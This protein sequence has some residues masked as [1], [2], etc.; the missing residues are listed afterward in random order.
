MLELLDLDSATSNLVPVTSTEFFSGKTKVFHSDGLFSESIFG[1]VDSPDRSN[2]YSFIELYTNVLHPALHPIIRRLD[3]RI[4]EAMSGEKKYTIEQNG[5]LKAD[6]SGELDGMTSVVKNFDKITFRGGNKTRDDL[7]KLIDHYKKAKQIFI[8]KTLVIPPPY[9]EIVIHD[10]GEVTIQP[11]NDYYLNI[12]KLST[13]M[14]SM[15]SGT[16]FD[17]LSYRMQI[18]VNDM[19]EFLMAKMSKKSGLLR[20]HML[21]KR[22]DFSARAVIV[23][24][25]AELKPNEIGVPFKLLVKLFEPFILFELLNSGR[26]PKELLAREMDAFNGSKLSSLSLRKLFI[27]IYK[28]DDIPDALYNL[29][30]EAVERAIKGKIVIAKR[31]P[32]LH[33][34]SVQAFYPKL[35]EGNAIKLAPLKTGAFNADFDGDQM[36]L[37]V[38]VTRQ[39]ME[40]AKDKMMV[41]ISKDGNGRLSDEFDK[42]VVIGTYTLTQKPTTPSRIVTIKSPDDAFDRHIYDKVRLGGITTTAGRVIFNQTL[43]NK[44]PFVNEPVGK[45]KL[46]E[47]ANDIFNMLGQDAYW[48]FADKVVKVAFKYGTLASPTFG[49][50]DLVLPPSIT[51]VKKKVETATPQEATDLLNAA[52]KKMEKYLV[53]NQTN[54]GVMGEAGALK[55]G[56]KQTRQILVSKGLIQDTEGNVMPPIA[57]S[58]AEGF[59]NKDFFMSGAGTRKGIS[60]RVLNTADTGY[61][62]RQLVYALQRVEADPR[63]YDCKTKKF[64]RLNVTKDIAKR[65]TGR[66][67]IVN[68]KPMPISNPDQYI[69]K[70]IPLKSPL[71]CRS[72]SICSTCYGNL[73]ERNRTPFVGILAAQVFGERSTQLIMQTFH[74]GGAVNVNTVDIL[75]AT[76][77]TFSKKEM[78]SFQKQFMQKGN[79]LIAK[80][81][82]KLI[83]HKSQYID[84]RKDIVVNKTLI[85]LA[86]GYFTLISQDGHTYDVTIDSPTIINLK[87]KQ[88]KDSPEKTEILFSANEPVCTCPPQTDNFADQVKQVKHLLSGKKPW[89]SGDHYCMK[90]YSEFTKNSI[91]ADMVHFEILASH[92]LRDRGNPS[93]PARMNDHY[94]AIVVNLKNIPAL[95]SWLS[96]LS[97]EDPNKSITAGLMYDRDTQESILEKVVN[98][99]L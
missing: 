14:S 61:L 64:F 35:I 65:L 83:I 58:Y 86:Y 55:G 48:E 56:Y 4:L 87:G 71:Y 77:V 73:L 13:Q 81:N 60:D 69:G 79:D 90:L 18:Y 34:E 70:T 6:D 10:S 12:L 76:E 49:L 37:Y 50:N 47:L 66:Y 97:F 11:L 9:R 30:S 32:A 19:Y 67:L 16:V 20:S 52:E 53:D 54:L 59:K 5:I 15:K 33:A 45:K 27:G 88:F 3:K 28:H 82:G 26:T 93:Y 21:G 40:E 39:A 36:A 63:L 99:N 96:A 91:N 68:G 7:I 51:S 92:L 43:P 95:E 23:G 75:K 74:T 41:S 57:E 29:L 22:V 42:D 1:P 25:A 98:G 38:P 78:V 31:D 89:K 94:D 80:V 8:D 62:S 85:E 84:L 2:N 24:G 46:A 17:L 72:K 44:I